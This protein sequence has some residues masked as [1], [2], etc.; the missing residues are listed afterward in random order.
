[1]AKMLQHCST[2]NK[3]VEIDKIA[4]VQNCPTCGRPLKPCSACSEV[5]DKGDFFDGCKSDCPLKSQYARA[6]GIWLKNK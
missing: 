4:K 1:M 3:K 2:C 6:M 5:M